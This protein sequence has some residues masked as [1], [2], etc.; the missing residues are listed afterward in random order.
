MS[1]SRPFVRQLGSQPG[2]QLNPLVDNTDGAAPDNSDQVIATLARLTRGRIDRPFRVNRSTLLRLT[3]PG[4]S[5]RASALNEAKLQVYE[6]L[7]NGAYEAVIQRLS[8]ADAV[9]SYGVVQ[10]GSGAVLAPTVVGGAVT[11]VAVTSGGTGYADGASV[12]FTDAAGAGA[13][14]TVTVAAGVITAVVVTSGGADYVAPT[15][16]TNT[17]PVFSVSPTIPVVD[18]F[19]LYFDHLD[20]HNDGIKFSI[21]ADSTPVVGVA[22]ANADVKIKFLDSDGVLLNAFEGSLDAAAKD[23][24]NQSKYLADIIASQSD[25]YNVVIAAGSTISPE[26]SAYGRDSSGTEKAATSGVLNCFSEGALVYTNADYDRCVS[27]LRETTLS[28]GYL[29]SGGTKAVALLGKLVSLAVETNLNMG[30]DVDGS[31]SVEAVNTFVASLN[32][33]THYVGIYWTPLE[34]NDPMNGGKA[35]W[36]SSGLNMGFR[37]ARNARVNAKGFAPK[38]YPVAGK[39]WPLNRTGVRQLVRPLEQEL[40]DLAKSK[41]NP[42]IYEIYNGGAKYVFTDSLTSAKTVVSY[43]KLISVAEMS[44]SI[45]LWVALYSKELLQLPMSEFVK[46]MNAFLGKLF[47]DAV[48]SKWLVPST[49]LPANAPF[50]YDVRKSEIRPADLVLVSYWTCYDGVARQVI[51]EQTL[52]K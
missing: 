34:C 36:G 37:C 22:V 9:R 52:V 40:S 17:V 42:V 21:H 49:N 2:V 50:L 41:V 14:A 44:S 33:D 45:D 25:S 27:A 23:D 12:V 30:L 16:V 31:L 3:G 38:N 15:A 24:F 1:G 11:V 46:R 26:N 20:C 35:V 7:Q 8:A 5:L 13:V 39:D 4:A 29:I 28:F 43:K 10:W 18:T 48:A 47:P 19:K 51:V 32:I 6:A